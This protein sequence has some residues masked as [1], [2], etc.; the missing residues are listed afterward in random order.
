[1]NEQ[2]IQESG[3][4][5]DSNLDAFAAVALIFIAVLTAVFWL[6]QR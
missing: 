4:N 3:T 6:S 1:M 5:G 2:E